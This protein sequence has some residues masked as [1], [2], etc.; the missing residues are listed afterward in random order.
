MR[1]LSTLALGGLLLVLA[2]TSN[3]AQILGT[4]VTPTFEVSPMQESTFVTSVQTTVSA[5]EDV[6][7]SAYMLLDL[8]PM[9]EITLSAEFMTTMALLA[10]LGA[11]GQL[12]MQDIER[13]TADFE[14][15]FGL[16]VLPSTPSELQ[17]RI[18]E[19]TAYLWQARRYAV[20]TQSL[21]NHIT[22]AVAHVTRIVEL[23]RILLGN[24]QGQ[25]LQVQL[26]AQ[27]NQTLATQT[28]Q[29]AAAQR[30]ETLEGAQRDLI[31]RGWNKMQA[32][33]WAGWPA[34]E[35]GSN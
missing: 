24:M 7:Q 32:E 11:E 28:L 29:Q 13:A 17:T 31:V 6:I 23:M 12:L 16:E 3:H 8:S 5:I 20:R 30:I 26:L 34:F 4:G 9:E 18:N 2:P 27:A 14:V 22:G 21:I 35:E 1:Y 25:Q 19:T 10:E 33:R 15:L